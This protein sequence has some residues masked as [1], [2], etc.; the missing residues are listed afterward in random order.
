MIRLWN[1]NRTLQKGT[2]EDK[3]IE[4]NKEKLS[5]KELKVKVTKSI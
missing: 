4:K 2:D 5:Y 3:Q 1:F